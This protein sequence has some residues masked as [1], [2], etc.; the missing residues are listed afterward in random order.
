MKKTIKHKPYNGNHCQYEPL[1]AWK[2]F[3][4]FLKLFMTLGKFW[5]EFLEYPFF[6][7]ISVAYA[8]L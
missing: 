4:D 5:N 8:I 1:K 7:I 3:F 6:F 2:D